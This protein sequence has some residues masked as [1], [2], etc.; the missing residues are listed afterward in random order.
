MSRL[1]C[2]NNRLEI[3]DELLFNCK[4]PEVGLPE[5]HL[6]WIDYTKENA[7]VLVEQFICHST[8]SKK[9]TEKI[10]S[11]NDAAFYGAV[12]AKNKPVIRKLVG[13]MF[14]NGIQTDI[15][16]IAYEFP[17]LKY[18]IRTERAMRGYIQFQETKEKINITAK[19]NT[20]AYRI[21]AI[22][23]SLPL[24]KQLDEKEENDDVHY[25]LNT[26][27][28]DVFKYSDRTNTSTLLVLLEDAITSITEQSNMRDLFEDWFEK[29]E[30]LLVQ[31]GEQET[32]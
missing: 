6:K 12:Y 22:F 30:Q 17:S 1:A 11:D 26:L 31:W 9:Y 27:I 29:L 20:S 14:V 24:F 28:K 13:Q 2:E 23:T 8:N 15:R 10:Y 32:F 5:P 18:M 7:H 21:V 4:E 16:R 3:V 19:R 25:F